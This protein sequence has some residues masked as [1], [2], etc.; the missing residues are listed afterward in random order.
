MG[1]DAR[2]ELIPVS[3]CLKNYIVLRAQGVQFEDN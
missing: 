1:T 2:I 3:G